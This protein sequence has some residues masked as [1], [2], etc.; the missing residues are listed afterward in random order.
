[1]LLAST[2]WILLVQQLWYSLSEITYKLTTHSLARLEKA[3]V[4]AA[5]MTNLK[6]L[7]DKEYSNRELFLGALQKAVGTKLPPRQTRLILLV[8]CDEESLEN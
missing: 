2:P 6:A 1:M 3:G 5:V 8:A 7:V 4:E